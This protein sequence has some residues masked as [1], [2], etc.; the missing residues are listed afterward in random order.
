MQ[1]NLGAEQIRSAAMRAALEELGRVAAGGHPLLL[2]GEPGVGKRW[3]AKAVHAARGGGPLQVVDGPS[4]TAAEWAAIEERAD[5]STLLVIE[6][7]RMPEALQGRLLGLLTAGKIRLI[8]TSCYEDW[9]APGALFRPDLYFRLIRCTIPPLRSRKDDLEALT[10]TLLQLHGG[11]EPLRLSKEAIAAILL[12][13]WPG[14]VAELSALLQRAV[15]LAVDGVIGPAQL[16]EAV[17]GKLLPPPPKA[18]FK[19][20]IRSAELLLIRWALREVGDDRT[21]AA[22][23]LGISRAAL[24]KKLKLLPELGSRGA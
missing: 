18:L 20:Y 11:E 1:L 7:G 5:G 9:Q 12:Y 24:Y 14:N 17:A 2:T 8:A 4:L 10:R 19:R 21:K 15:H 6:L 13:D 3:W 23:W 22:K 16:P